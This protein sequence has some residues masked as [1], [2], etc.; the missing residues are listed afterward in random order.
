MA[1]SGNISAPDPGRDRGSAVACVTLWHG[2]SADID[3][4]DH[5]RISREGLHVGTRMQADMRARGVVL[6]VRVD[7]G[8]SRRCRDSGGNW[9]RR[10]RAARAAGYDSI[11]YL[12]RWEGI[13]AE[14]IDALAASGDLSKLDA[15]SDTEFRKLVPEAAD[16]FIILHG[17]DIRVLSR[18][19]LTSTPTPD[20][21]GLW[22]ALHQ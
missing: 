22:N 12:N 15:L 8:R 13:P 20:E 11:V 1:V 6:E 16:S 2:T 10:I 18:I 7:L 3:V 21:E 9:G 4:I 19:D 5:D 17:N 14:R